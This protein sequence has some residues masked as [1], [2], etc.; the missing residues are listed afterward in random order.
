MIQGFYYYHPMPMDEFQ[1]LLA[2]QEA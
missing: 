1:R 2:K